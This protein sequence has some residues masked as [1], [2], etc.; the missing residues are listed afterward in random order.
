MCKLL[1]SFHGYREAPKQWH[2]KFNKTL[3][4]VGFVLNEANKCVYY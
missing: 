3:I 1:K 4:F 2:E